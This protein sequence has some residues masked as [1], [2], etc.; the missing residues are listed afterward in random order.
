MK[1]V[2]SITTKCS[3]FIYI[4]ILQSLLSCSVGR[5]HLPD[6]LVERIFELHE[7]E[8]EAL[9]ADISQ[10][11][12]FELAGRTTLRY[13][14]CQFEGRI[15]VSGPKCTEF[16]G[17]RWS[18]FQKSIANVSV[19]R[20]ERLTDQVWFDFDEVSLSNG[21]SFKGLMFSSKPPQRIKEGSLDGYRI[22]AADRGQFGNYLIHR[23]I[24][25]NW[26]MF[27]FVQR[28][29]GPEPTIKSHAQRWASVRFWTR[30]TRTV[31]ASG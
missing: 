29:V 10:D 19:V 3:V 24:R 31:S 1:A 26:Y 23:K 13:S 6:R 2:A 30:L 4:L 14:V 16:A 11:H 22:E 15:G 5:H 20:V 18:R 27:L 25:A 8:F 9:V 7:R 21:D 17:E 28:V 12:R